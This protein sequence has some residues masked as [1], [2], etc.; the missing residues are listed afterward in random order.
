VLRGADGICSTQ[1]GRALIQSGGVSILGFFFK[2]KGPQE[3]RAGT[4]GFEWITMSTDRMEALPD[5]QSPHHGTPHKQ[6]DAVTVKLG[7]SIANIHAHGPE[8]LSC[9]PRAPD[10]VPEPAD[11]YAVTR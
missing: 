9:S 6:H 8:S 3:I 5:P 7:P 2:G 4:M 1:Q 11:R 10:A